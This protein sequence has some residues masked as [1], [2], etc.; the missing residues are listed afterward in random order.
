VDQKL[1]TL[2]VFPLRYHENADQVR[3]G[4][5]K[6]GQKFGSLKSLRHLQYSGTAFQVV[7]GEPV[8][9]FVS[10]RIMVDAAQFQKINP[11]YARPSIIK[12]ANSRSSDSNTIDLWD[13]LQDRPPPPPG[14]NEVKVNRVDLDMQD[15]NN[16]ILCS[17]TVSYLSFGS[18]RY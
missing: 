1:S 4:L 3:A 5:V 16:L 8:A 7:K 6:C 2:V 9:T 14:A 15:E 17:P 10:S 12:V 18:L 11:N 13:F